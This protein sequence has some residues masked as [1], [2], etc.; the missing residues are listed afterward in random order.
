MRQILGELCDLLGEQKKALENMIE[1]SREERQI[2]I[3]GESDKLE[4]VV[5]LELRELSKLGA[6]EKKRLALH[7]KIASE[8]G[9]AEDDVTVT[10]ITARAKPEEREQIIKLQEELTA[11]ISQHTTLNNENREL[12]KSHIEYSESMLELMLGTED[13]LNNFYGGDGKAAPE[14][15]K[16]TG[17]FDGK[18]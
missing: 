6:V 10:A 18:A 14:R 8:L 3:K 7:K 15:K 4:S 9:M 12:V 2:L 16:T 1:L 5:R 11:L 13:P 17:F